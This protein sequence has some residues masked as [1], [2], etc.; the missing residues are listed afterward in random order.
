ML[1]GLVGLSATVFTL[2]MLVDAYQRRAESYWYFIIL[3]PLGEWA[4][5]FA[6][7]I[8]DFNL[9]FIENL[10]KPPPASLKTL[11]RRVHESPSD[12]NRLDLGW[13]H[14]ENDAPAEAAEMFQSVLRRDPNDPKAL[15]G[16]G[17]ARIDLNQPASAV[18]PLERLVER[19]PAFD[20]YE[21]WHDLAY[22]HWE[23]ENRV[24]AVDVLRR[25]VS[26]SPRVK[27]KVILGSYL[28]RIGEP[29]EARAVLEE[30]LADF[31]ELPRHLRREAKRW[32]KQAREELASLK[33]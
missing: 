26:T 11:Q 25:L 8:H 31:D 15:H 14:L 18:S 4:Y 20:G 5:F 2:W 17:L 22:A 23:S 32:V 19:D 9:S 1:R 33:S 6:V 3:M 27:H 21:V 16:L 24:G 13:A 29:E 12:K 28:G 7:K 10:T 30:A